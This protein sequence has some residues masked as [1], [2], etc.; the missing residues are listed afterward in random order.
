MP[1]FFY[2]SGYFFKESN[3][4]YPLRYCKKKVR[5]L[6]WVFLKWTIPVLLLHNVFCMT[7]IYKVE[8][9]EWS[10]IFK[11]V[12]TLIVLMI[13]SDTLTGGVWFH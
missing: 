10:S 6:Y 4:L 7:G 3:Y 13:G 2:L 5:T 8:L 12:L 11:R 1:L 9:L